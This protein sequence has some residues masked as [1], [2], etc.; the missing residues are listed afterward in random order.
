MP[1]VG[2]R[3]ANG[4]VL[5]GGTLSA[6][7]AIDGSAKDN[8]IAG[9]YEIENT[10]L[11]G[12]NLGSK[13]VGLAA[14]GGIKTGDTLDITTSSADVRITKAGSETTNIYSV[15]P[16]LGES[17]GSG[18]VSPSGELDFHLISKVTSAKGLNKFG[19]NLLTKLNSS[20]AADK[21]STATGIPINITGTAENPVITADVSGLLK[22]N[23]AALRSK[24]ADILN[25]TGLSNLFSKKK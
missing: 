21:P 22:G 20:S 3:L 7:F 15:L 6:H 25:K 14:L 10:Q 8:V 5:K 24:G 9:S 19:V 11:V 1:A 17:T 16:A 4:A 13:I 23:V 2:V 18:T 12:Y